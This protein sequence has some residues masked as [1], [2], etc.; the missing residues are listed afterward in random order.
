MTQQVT[1]CAGGV[2]VERQR[3]APRRAPV[4][5]SSVTGCRRRIAIAR[6][7]TAVGS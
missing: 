4:P 3:L 6:S 1:P 2:A 5:V 7:S